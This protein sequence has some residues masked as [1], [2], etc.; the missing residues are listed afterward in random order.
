[1]AHAPVFAAG[2]ETELV[3]VWGRDRASATKLAERHGTSP[4]TSLDELIDRSEVVTFAVPPVVQADLALKAVA[5]GRAVV[6]EKPIAG[7]LAGAQKLADAVSEA[8]VVSMVA[9][10]WRYADAVKKFVAAAGDF[11]PAGGRGWFVSG[12]LLGGPFATPWR[13]AEG[14][15]PDL[16]PHLLDLM[17]ATLGPVTAIRAHGDSLRWVGLLLEHQSGAVS[18][19]SMSASVPIQTGRSGVELYGAGGVLEINCAA[20]VGPEAF[21]TLRAEVAEAVRTGIHHPLDVHRGLYLQ[22]LIED[23]RAQLA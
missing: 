12:A 6:L 9:L 21:A 15:L 3:G 17:D 23:A 19:A 7:D 1:M 22:R 5:A 16:G 18:E 14:A 2:P 11:A 20:E 13:L 4:V 10:S 8:G